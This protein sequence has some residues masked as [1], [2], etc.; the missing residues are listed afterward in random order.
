MEWLIGLFLPIGVCVVLPIAIVWIV[1]RTIE[2]KT[3]KNAEIIIK[4]IENDSAVDTD[5]LVA[6]LGKREKTDKQLLQERLLKGCIFTFIGV[7]TAILA[8]FIYNE[9]IVGTEFYHYIPLS[10]SALCIPV[11]I[12]YLV[13]YFVSRKSVGNQAETED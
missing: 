13:V 1:F 7:A 10:V 12:A 2:N 11:G 3:N 9:E 5:K 8:A 4:T 6:A